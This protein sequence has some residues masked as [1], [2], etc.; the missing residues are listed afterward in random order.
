MG[1]WSANQYPYFGGYLSS[2]YR[3]TPDLSFNADPASGVY[4]YS[5]YNGGWFIV[6]GTSVS[7]PALAGIVNLANNRLGQAPAAGGFYTNEENNLLYD[8]L[9]AVKMYAGNFYDVTTG[10]NGCTV[11][12]KWDYCTGVGSPRGLGGK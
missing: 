3:H 5:G 10:T 2:A 6:G 11:G 1:P 4:V 7:S 8:Q 9:Y 12:T